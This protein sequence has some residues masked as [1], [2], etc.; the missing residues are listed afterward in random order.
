MS[1]LKIFG[2]VSLALIVLLVIS[3][4]IFYYFYLKPMLEIKPAISQ[5]NTTEYFNESMIDT[6]EKYGNKMMKNQSSLSIAII[7][8]GQVHYYGIER[9]DDKFITSDNS[10][11]LYQIGSISKVFTSSLLAKFVVENEIKLDESIDKYIGFS[12]PNNL[13]LNW[14]ELSNHTSGLPGLPKENILNTLNEADNPYVKYDSKWLDN[15]L[16]NVIEQD[17]SL[18]KKHEYSNL[19]VAVLGNSLGY[20][21]KQS[22]ESLCEQYIF[23]KFQMNNTFFYEPKYKEKL[24]PSYDIDNS[25]ATIWEL[26]AFNP[27]GGI[28]S[29]VEDLSKFMIA[30]LDEKNA[31]LQLTQKATLV[32]SSKESVGLGWFLL[33]SKLNHKVLFHNGSTI[34]YT[35]SLSLDLDSK[36][37]VVILSNVNHMLGK[38]DFDALNFAL[39]KYINTFKDN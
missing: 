28:V 22:Y 1:K 29:N 13:K 16:R 36:K 18:N 34:N 32:N 3:G 9:K 10:K 12:L 27:T 26:K 35:S 15:Y 23:N 4:F 5:L 17:K 39:L 2:I 37:G 30:Q 11:H 25:L 14:K 21:K 7:D 20:F 31:A 38:K 19:G 33:T 6:L 24:V 8:N